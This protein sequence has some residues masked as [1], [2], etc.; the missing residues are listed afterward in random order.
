MKPAPFKYV[1]P[2][3]LEEALVTKAEHGDDAMFL[4]GGQSLV[5]A[6]N[7]RL[8]APAVLIDINGIEN[9]GTANA[10]SESGE[11]RLGALTRHRDVEFNP[12]IGNACPLLREAIVHVAHPQIRNRGTLCGNLAHADPASEMPAVVLALD[13]RMRLVSSTGERWVAASDFFEGIYTT[14]CAE[15]EMLV[16]VALPKSQPETVSCFLE[17]AR[18][19]GDYAMMGVAVC[20]TLG[21]GDFCESASV[22]FCGAGETPLLA[23][24]ACDLLTGT[25]LTAESIE[26]AADSARGEIEPLGSVHATPDY[27]R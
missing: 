6:M 13:A 19:P 11:L 18:R 4:A 23:K 20:V 24:V 8:A 15:D 17:V 21:P 5:P 2:R 14:S 7:F 27:Q 22:V 3:T 25:Q 26:A 16:E 12:A 10:D 1:A 9:L